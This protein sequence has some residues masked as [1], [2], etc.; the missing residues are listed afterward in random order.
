MEASYEDYDPDDAC[1]GLW[2]SSSSI[3]R[4]QNTLAGRPLD[5]QI[6]CSLFG[7]VT[8]IT[9]YVIFPCYIRKLETL[10]CTL[11]ETFSNSMLRHNPH[12]CMPLPLIEIAFHCT[13]GV[14]FE[15]G[16]CHMFM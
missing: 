6:L 8:A 13:S 15:R 7:S 11:L 9:V 16:V 10:P 14:H 4:I 2:R 5:E 3:S 12:L 1:P